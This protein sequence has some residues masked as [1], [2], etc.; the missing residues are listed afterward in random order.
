VFVQVNFT[1]PML[2]AIMD[3][4][5]QIRNMSV[6]AHVDHGGFPGKAT[7]SPAPLGV[8]GVLVGCWRCRWLARLRRALSSW[9]P[10]AHGAEIRL[11]FSERGPKRVN[12][13]ISVA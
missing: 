12:A 4:T 2:R 3:R 7:L 8:G 6:I 11:P 10:R 5:K 9:C 13:R 1:I